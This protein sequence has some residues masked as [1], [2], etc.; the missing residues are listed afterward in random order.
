MLKGFLQVWDSVT[1]PVHRE[2]SYYMEQCVGIE[3][4]R[5]AEEVSLQ[6]L[7]FESLPAMDGALQAVREMEEDGLQV[8]IC[9]SPNL[10]SQYCCQEK[11]NWIRKHLGA[12]YLGKVLLTHDKVRQYTTLL[13][14]LIRT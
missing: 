14:F 12:Q 5:A 6:P 7:F 2:R 8:Y 9:T 4:N 11:L 1:A 10:A 13:F 3:F